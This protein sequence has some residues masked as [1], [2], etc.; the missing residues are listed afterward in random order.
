MSTGPTGPTGPIDHDVL[1][2]IL[3]GPLGVT[4]ADEYLQT[5]ALSWTGP[6]GCT[7][8][9]SVTTGPTGPIDGPTGTQL[10]MTG[11]TGT[12]EAVAVAPEK[13]PA[14]M[15]AEDVVAL[16]IIKAT[17]PSA[18]AEW[19]AAG[20]PD[21]FVF[22]AIPLAQPGV[23]S[24]DIV[25]NTGQYVEYILETDLKTLT[26]TLSEKFPGVSV[27]WSTIRGEFRLHVTRAS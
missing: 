10:V 3:N 4:G 1:Q 20:C 2:S 16:S 8:L 9:F 18:L 15:E 19:E 14:E 5:V 13:T 12:T 25:R 7:G 24:D 23:C 6:T 21:L 27:S 17:D 26:T 11:A 22:H